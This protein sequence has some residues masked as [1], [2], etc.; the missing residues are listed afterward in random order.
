MQGYGGLFIISLIVIRRFFDLGLYQ[1]L[2]YF[3]IPM[4]WLIGITVLYLG[5][6]KLSRIE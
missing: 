5:K 1:L 4:S 3:T 6:R 2:Y